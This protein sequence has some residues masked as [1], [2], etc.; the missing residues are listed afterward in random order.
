MNDKDIRW[1]Q[2]YNNF[3]RALN[4]LK[5]AVEAYRVRDLNLLEKQGLIQSFEFT[6]ELA[7]KVL[8]DFFEYQGNFNLKGSR[9]AVKEA[10]RNNL[11]SDGKLWLQMIETRN[12]TTHTYDQNT[13]EQ[14]L[15]LIIQDYY[16]AILDLGKVMNSL[17]AEIE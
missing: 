12:L 11:I 10:F 3:I 16:P 9:D 14:V 2:R 7:W 15:S 13:A 4:Q 6:H 8:K 1:V 17:K 5:E